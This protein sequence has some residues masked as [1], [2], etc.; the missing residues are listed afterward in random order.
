M[1]MSTS[2]YLAGIRVKVER[3]KKHIRD[4]DVE[5]RSFLGSDIKPYVVAR[6]RE[7]KTG[8]LVFYVTSVRDVPLEFSAILGDALNNLRGV[9]DY[10][11]YAL[12]VRE[13]GHAPGRKVSFPIFCDAKGY[14]L[15]KAGKV[16]AMGQAAKE[17]IDAIKPYKGGN[18]ALW[19]LHH[20]NNID[21]HRLLIVAVIARQDFD[22]GLKR[23]GILEFRRSPVKVGNELL[24]VPADLETDVY[25]EPFFEVAFAESEIVECEPVVPTLN[26]FTETVEGV[27]ARLF[28]FL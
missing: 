13:K 18:D 21:K 20:L 23:R 5:V 2:E 10:L 4:L 12:V 19:C 8:D 16:G 7:P 25:V 22:K 26:M 9:L 1:G 14:E 15:G 3:A 11:A 24:R 27:F 6:E 17:A 28:V